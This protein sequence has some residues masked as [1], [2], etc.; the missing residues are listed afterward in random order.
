MIKLQRGG[1]TN[2]LLASEYVICDTYGILNETSRQ[3]NNLFN[4]CLYQVRQNFFQREPMKPY[5][6]YN[7]LFKKKYEARENML[8]RA[9]GYVQSAQQTL[10]E[11]LE[12]WI[13]W[14]KALKKYYN[15]PKKFTGKPRMPKYLKKDSRHTF[16][17][18]NQNAKVKNGYLVIDKLKVRVKLIDTIGKVKRVAF[19]PLSKNFFKMT[20]QHE[21]PD[22]LPKANNGIVMGIDPG[23]D[24]LF[25]CV[26][27]TE[28]RPLIINGKGLKSVNQWYNKQRSALYAKHA[29]Y[30]QCCKQV[31]QKDGK[32]VTTYYESKKTRELTDWR[33]R[34]MKDFAHKATR[35]IIDY[36]LS[37][38]V[39]T[40]VIGHNKR[41]KN[42]SNMGTQNNQ[43]FVTIPH[44]MMM[45]MLEY[46]ATLAGITV[47]RTEESYTSQT[48]FLDNELPIKENG[49]HAR[50]LK[51]L[52]PAKR[53]IKRGLFKS[54]QGILINAD[55]NGALQIIKKVFPEM[56]LD[57]IVGMVLSPV[58]YN[59]QF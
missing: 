38:E 49:N 9:L 3:A 52:K 56:Q 24:N 20:V 39:T 32:I 14:R 23:L 42:K 29:T 53:R 12:V 58:K 7:A 6:F 50:K 25:T 11:V 5:E 13:A 40:I 59:V 8:Y 10:K 48:S 17:V 37:C 47:I 43:N 55:V 30:G 4:A 34:K 31:K 35:R 2:M 41:Q 33:N 18:T 19:K 54:D 44:V 36:A 28:N 27:N 51:G 22:V 46:K 21:I 15:N 1:E 16:F 57:G 45:D 26:T